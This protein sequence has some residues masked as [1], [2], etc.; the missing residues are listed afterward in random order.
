MCL[1]VACDIHAPVFDRVNAI[2]CYRKCGGVRL[3]RAAVDTV[4]SACHSGQIVRSVERHWYRPRK[5]LLLLANSW[6]CDQRRWCAEID[7]HCW[8]SER[9]AVAG[10]IGDSYLL[11]LI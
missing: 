6:N 3:H 1:C 10:V 5:P 11:T 2:A 9:R 4:E 7:M 8:R